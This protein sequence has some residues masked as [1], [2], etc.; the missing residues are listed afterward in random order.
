[1]VNVAGA[2]GAAGAVMGGICGGGGG[3]GSGGG[4]L[5]PTWLPPG[6]H[7]APTWLPPGSHLASYIIILYN[8]SARLSLPRIFDFYPTMH[9][10]SMVYHRFFFT[11]SL[12]AEWTVI[13]AL[14]LLPPFF[15]ASFQHQEIQ[16][17]WFRRR[18]WKPLFIL[19]Y[20]LLLVSEIHNLM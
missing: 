10:T 14:G 4:H 8:F 13:L 3:G 9:R 17:F 16:R 12:L 5:A 2:A 18:G 6:S 11:E 15:L 19:L 7:L 20:K 1:M